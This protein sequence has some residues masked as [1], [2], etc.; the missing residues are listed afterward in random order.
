MPRDILIVLALVAAIAAPR[1]AFEIFL[2]RLG[3]ARRA[4]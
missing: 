3:R 1:V 2:P 4:A